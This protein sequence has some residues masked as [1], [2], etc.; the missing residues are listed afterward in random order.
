ML[1]NAKNGAVAIGD[2]EMNYVSFGYG[3]KALVLLP[4]LSDGLGTVKG[5]ALLLAKPY[6]LF[7]EKYTVYI[8]SR[9]N[10]MLETYSI[11]EMA[12]DMAQAMKKLGLKKAFVTG[13]SQGGMIAQYLAIDHAEMV[14][15]LVIAVSAPR[16]NETLRECVDR[17]IDYA[18]EGK[19]KKLMIDTAEK[20][21]SYEYL[22]KLRRMYPIIGFIGKPKNYKR[23]LINANAILSFDAFQEL[24]KINC[25]TLII[26]GEKDRIVGIE[27]SYELH[28]QIS[29]SKLYVYKELGHA[30]YEE[31]EDFNKRVF[32]FLESEQQ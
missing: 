11:R 7:F 3:E 25:P 12:D 24:K 26:G 18:K 14:E 15:K 8:F 6:E 5:K 4:G 13:V 23:F 22:K 1:W 28:E 29:D 19:H 10:E 20:S 16:V 17:W 31:A 30:A 9:K 32:R 21:Y 2:T 27:G